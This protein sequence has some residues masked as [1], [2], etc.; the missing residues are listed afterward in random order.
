MTDSRIV[1]IHIDPYDYKNDIQ[2]NL[3]LSCDVSFALL[4]FTKPEVRYISILLSQHMLTIPLSSLLVLF[5]FLIEVFQH[6][7]DIVT[8]V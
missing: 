7:C 8:C 1:D 3:W 6:P 5:F 4:Y 2:V